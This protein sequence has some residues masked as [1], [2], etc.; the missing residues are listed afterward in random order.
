[1]KYEL[2]FNDIK[3][4]RRS[5][6]ELE[7]A[8]ESVKVGMGKM[9]MISEYTP[10]LALNLFS[11]R[12]CLLELQWMRGKLEEYKKAREGDKGCGVVGAVEE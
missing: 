1:M 3:Y 7:K 6:E 12:D 4:R 2:S 10:D 11:I 5:D 9:V 8:L